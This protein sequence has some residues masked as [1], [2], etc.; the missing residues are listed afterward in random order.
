MNNLSESFNATILLQRDKPILT[1]F[2]WIRN[3][4]MGRFATLREK[5]DRYKGLV[6]AKPLRR[7]DREIEKSA[8]WTPTY[9]GRLTFQ[10]SHTLLSDSFVVDLAQKTC[11]CN[12]W[13]LVGIPCR[14]S[15]AAIYRKGDDPRN[16]VSEYYHKNTYERCYSEVITPLNGQNKWPKT[17]D[18]VILPPMYKRGPGRPKKLRRREPDEANQHKWQRTNTSHRCKTCQELGHNARTCKKNKQIVLVPSENVRQD[19]PTQASQ[20]VEGNVP[21]QATEPATTNGPK[22]RGRPKGSMNAGTSNSNKMNKQDKPQKKKNNKTA[23]KT[24]TQQT[25]EGGDAQQN[26]EGGNA[27]ENV[28]G[29][30]AQQNVEGGNAEENVEGGNAEE[31]VEGGNAQQNVEGGNAEE[32]HIFDKYCDW[33]AETLEAILSCEGVLDIP[34]IRV[35]TTP[36]KKAKSVP[37]P[38][39]KNHTNATSSTADQSK[40]SPSKATQSRLKVFFGKKPPASKQVPSKSDP[41]KI[42]SPTKKAKIKTGLASTQSKRQSERLK[43]LKVRDIPGPGREPDNP[44]VINEDDGDENNSKN[45]EDICRSMTQ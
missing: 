13:E 43:T 2:E 28:E 22:K 18:P 23:A 24:S 11:T 34:P 29:G 9:A 19:I 39:E 32:H 33:D 6:M 27:E 30:N 26:V 12:M 25:V 40:N 41:V 45:W 37:I 5:V 38:V 16:Y 4:L 10:V 7:L 14:H 36:V 3:Y 1:M 15:V 21:N 44:V 31:N 20:T 17:S 8:S 35:D 42:L